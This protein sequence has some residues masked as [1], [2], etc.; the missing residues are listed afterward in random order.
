MFL[1]SI[2]CFRGMPKTVIAIP[3]FWKSEGLA[4]KRDPYDHSLLITDEY[5]LKALVDSI[6]ILKN[7]NFSLVFIADSI[8]KSIQ[9][10]MEYKINNFIKFMKN[11]YNIQ[12]FLI[13][14]KQLKQLQKLIKKRKFT[15]LFGFRAYSKTRN[16]AL[17]IAKILDADILIFIDDDEYFHDPFFVKKARENIG[18]TIKGKKVHGVAGYYL[19]K[20]MDYHVA[21]ENKLK[22]WEKGELMNKTFDIF[23]SPKPRLKIAPIA[24]GGNLVLSKELYTK[25]P[26]DPK[27]PRGED[28]DYLINSRMFG[29]NIFLDNKLSIIHDPPEHYHIPWKVMY[30]DF[31]RFLYEREKILSQKKVKISDLMPY[32]GEFLKESLRENFI[33]SQYILLKDAKGKND[34]VSIREFKKNI[35]IA[36]K[37]KFK[38]NVFKGYCKIKKDWEE[39]NKLIDSSPTLK[40][41]ALK[42]ISHNK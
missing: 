40:S 1:Y 10:E 30:N 29:Y 34:K 14:E 13:V 2:K 19:N 38:G 12:G 31:Y 7:K 5:T 15:N 39:L 16:T 28:I 27:I 17:I 11:K 41:K 21:I 22:H 25:I 36:K 6:R 42:I 20:N 3:T 23:I 26:F 18:K 33:K 37:L 32:P 24:F 4:P 8:N 35:S 9:K